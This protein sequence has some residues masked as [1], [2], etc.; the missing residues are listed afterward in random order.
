MDTLSI[1]ARSELMGRIRSKD[2]KPELMV[3]RLTHQ[4][5]YRYRLHD[6]KLPGSPDLVF[7][8]FRKIIFVHGCFW[9]CHPG[10]RLNRKPK[11]RQ[12][13]W[14]P[15]LQSNIDRDQRNVIRLQETG[16]TILTIWE[17]ETTDERAIESRI[18]TFLGERVRR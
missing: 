11:S 5:G 15:K 6:K 17:C 2:T 1:S 14:L 13:F 16:W 4:L 12:D 3:R 8:R 7:P 10:C 18:R 9:H